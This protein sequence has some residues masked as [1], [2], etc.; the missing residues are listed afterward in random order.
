[1][2]AEKDI[3]HEKIYGKGTNRQTHRQ[4]DRQT[5]RQINIMTRTGLRAGPS[6]NL[7]HHSMCRG[8]IF[9]SFFP[10]KSRGRLSEEYLWQT[11]IGV[12]PA[13]LLH[14][15]AAVGLQLSHLLYGVHCPGVWIL[16]SRTRSV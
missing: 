1:M 13:G 16:D 6:E 14:P 3:Y 5:R 12:R 2:L 9:I 11:C 4:T 10:I 15:W 7:L 8:N